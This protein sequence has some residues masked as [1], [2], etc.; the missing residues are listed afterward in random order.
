MKA[1][2][3]AEFCQHLN[4]IKCLKILGW[5]QT[6]T[7]SCIDAYRDITLGKPNSKVSRS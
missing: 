5:L 2:I 6:H 1:R 4:E 7:Y 3:Y